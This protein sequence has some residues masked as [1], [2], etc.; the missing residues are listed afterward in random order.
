MKVVHSKLPHC[1]ASGGR[2]R[3]PHGKRQGWCFHQPATI[4]NA[5]NGFLHSPEHFFTV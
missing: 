4:W 3:L 5:P 2:C 1:F